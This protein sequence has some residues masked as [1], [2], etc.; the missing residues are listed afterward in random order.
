MQWKVQ[1]AAGRMLA[2]YSGPSATVTIND[3]GCRIEL[4]TAEAQPGT[5]EG[6]AGSYRI[7]SEA[8][9]MPIWVRHPKMN[10]RPSD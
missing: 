5:G 6:K 4:N 2:V 8:L 10:L 1:D 7:R 9:G 3:N